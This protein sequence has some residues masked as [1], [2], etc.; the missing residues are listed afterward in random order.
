MKFKTTDEL[1]RALLAILPNASIGEDL[2]GQIV[3]YTNLQ[4]A[5]DGLKDMDS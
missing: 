3:V 2:D 1:L 5:K 4:E